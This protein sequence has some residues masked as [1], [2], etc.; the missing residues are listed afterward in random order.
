MSEKKKITFIAQ[1]PPPIHGLSK[2]V[3]I[4]YNS[5]QLQCFALR[6]IN[7][8]NNQKILRSFLRVLRSKDDLYYLSLSQSALGNLR[9]LIFMLLIHFKRKPLLLHLHGGRFGKLV[10]QE[11]GGIQRRLN[12]WLISQ[13]QGAIVLSPSLQKNFQGLLPASRIFEV[14][15]CVDQQLVP[16]QKTL[17]EKI[18]A[19]GQ[20]KIKQVLYLSNFNPEKGYLKVL[21]LA[22]LE[23]EAPV[24]HHLHFNFAGTFFSKKEQ[25]KFFDYL[26]KYQLQDYVSYHG[27]VTGQ[28][29]KDL[30]LQA[31]FF[32]LLTKYPKEGQPISLLEAMAN[33]C[34]VI[35]T[36]HAGIPDLISET[37]KNGLVVDKNQIDP[38]FIFNKLGLL[39]KN[40]PEWR[41]VV[42]NNRRIAAAN[43]TESQ[44]LERMKAC[45]LQSLN[46]E[47]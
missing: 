3:T 28:A 43:Y 44:Y 39:V 42:L 5:P 9:D 21:E 29:K 40:A 47:K 12:V 7:T 20:K 32:I 24:K 38:E 37:G 33:A 4:L 25:R 10:T 41:Q 6:A 30:L 14:P 17:Q 27:V 13:A 19:Y 34:Y 1:F 8:T 26:H 31:D 23:K 16:D 35:T 36:N 15:N 2:A 18:A 45:F 46:S 11:M 22:R